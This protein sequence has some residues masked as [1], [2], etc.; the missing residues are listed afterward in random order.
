MT[1][2]FYKKLKKSRAGVTLIELLVV[3]AIIG[4][5]ATIGFVALTGST[6]SA[7][8]VKRISDI[9][10]IKRALDI[11]RVQNAGSFEPLNSVAAN[12]AND[13]CHEI[14]ASAPFTGSKIQELLPVVPT[15]PAASATANAKKYYVQVDNIYQPT[16]FRVIATLDGAIPAGSLSSLA[17]DD[18]VGSAGTESGAECACAGK[19][20]VGT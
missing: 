14:T 11:S 16:S 7:N 1:K 17:G 5:I 12:D 10:T 6:D 4:V 2:F 15:D 8:D 19:Y 3:V 20:C 18:D 13:L 9:N